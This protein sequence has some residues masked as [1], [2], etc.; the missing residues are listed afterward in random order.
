[1]RMEE[2]RKNEVGVINLENN[3]IINEIKITKNSMKK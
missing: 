3:N 2:S 1:M